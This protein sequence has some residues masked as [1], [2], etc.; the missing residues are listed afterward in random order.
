MGRLTQILRGGRG[1]AAAAISLAVLLG[2]CAGGFDAGEAVGGS[3]EEAH[4]MVEDWIVKARTGADNGGWSLLYPTVRE[5]LIGD[6]DVYRAALRTADWDALR[7]DIGEVGV[8]DGEYR[9]SVHVA[10]GVDQV[11]DFMRRWGLIQFPPLDGQ[12]TDNGFM[13]VRISPAG[14]ERGIQATGG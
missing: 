12:P 1:I 10:G 14:P 5:S 3:P 11:P 6:V 4:Q 9:V 7:Y 2:A 13:V 8:S